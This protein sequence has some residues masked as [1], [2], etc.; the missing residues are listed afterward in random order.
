MNLQQLRSFR[1]VVND[2]MNLTRAARSLHTTQPSITRRLKILEQELGVQLF[3]R[4]KGRVVRLSSSGRVLLPMILRALNAVEDLHHVADDCSSGS[5]GE[6]TIATVNTHLRSALPPVIAKFVEEFPDIQ[7]RL[8]QGTRTQLASWVATGE[9]D[10]CVCTLPAQHF[11]DLIF[12][13]CFDVHRAIIVPVGHPLLNEKKVAL[14]HIA[15]Y[16][17]VTYDREYT[18][19]ADIERAFADANLRIH[20]VISA[21]DGETMKT[22]VRSG[23]GVGIMSLACY[24]ESKDTGLRMIPASHLFKSRVVHIGTRRE[25]RLNPHAVRFLELF[26]SRVHAEIVRRIEDKTSGD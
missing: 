2:G 22:F 4:G 9:A 17:I 25:G 19:R 15:A 11:P 3:E 1:Q 14:R 8:R 20:V 24:E 7:L 23:L 10:F 5:I 21:A 26:S 13:P 18:S 12:D 16:P 6:L